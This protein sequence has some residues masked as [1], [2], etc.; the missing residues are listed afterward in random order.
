[1]STDEFHRISHVNTAKEAWTI[2]ETTYEGTKKVKDIMLTT[3]LEELKMGDDESFDSFY[4]KLNGIIN[5]KLNLGEKIEDAKVV[6]K[7]LRSLPESFLAK[8]TAIEE[9]KDLDKIKTKELIGS[10]QTY[11]LGL[12]SHKSSKSL[13]LKTI[14]DRMDD[15]FEENDVEKEVAFLEKNFRKF[16]KMKNSGKSFSKGKFS[17][18]RSDRKEFKKKDGKDSQS[19]QGIVCYECNSHEHL[20][21]KCPNFLRGK[22]KV[23]ATTL[24]DSESSNSDTDEE[25]DSEGNYRAF[26]AITFVDS[27]DELSNLVDELGNHFE[28][29]EVKESEDE[30]VCQNEGE[31]NLQE[32]YDS[33]LED[34]GKY[35]KVVNLAVKKMKNVEEE[36][37]CIL[38]QC[39]EAKC[40]VEGLKGELV[41]AY[42][43]IK[44][45]ELEI[46]QANVK[47]ERMSIKKLDNVLPSQKSSHEKTGLGYTAEGSS[48]SEPKKEVRFVSAKNEENLK[49][50]KLEIETPVV[51][52]RTISTKPK[53]KMEVIT[54]KSKGASSETHVSS[55]WHTRAHKTELF[56]TSC[57]QEG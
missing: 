15:S 40:E 11:E 18:S 29:E 48:S 24:S 45:L 9:S 41:E 28:G 53:E 55:L 50:V 8:V 4:G 20:K 14:N 25:C 39:K 12:P 3:R 1:M 17:S 22:G 27:M 31:N 37:R 47:V 38:M 13:T 32:A 49:E 23:F 6:R 54:Q 30:E 51:V 43:K 16:L 57:T 5:A 33:L 46:I 26:V 7:I 44:F 10:L 34:C 42:S 52:K 36:H 21:K 35:T 56:Q 2:L 19:P